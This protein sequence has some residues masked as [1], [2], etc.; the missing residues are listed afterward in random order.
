MVKF[1]SFSG[2]NLIDFKDLVWWSGRE[3][4]WY[5]SEKRLL[6]ATPNIQERNRWV[7]VLSWMIHENNHQ[8]M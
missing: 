1:H 3:K 7:T 2:R 4:E 8:E 5:T 6:F